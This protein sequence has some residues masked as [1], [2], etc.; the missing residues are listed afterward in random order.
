MFPS[1]LTNWLLVF[2]RV[3]A[4]LAL[5]PV[6][7]ARN[8]PVQ[9]RLAIGALVAF[10]VSS[11][12]PP[13]S[14]AHLSFSALLGMLVLELIIG[15][16]LGLITNL[17]FSSLEVAGTVIASEMGLN[18]AATL[19]P[20]SGKQV[21]TPGVLLYYL[22]TILFLSLDLHHWLLIAFQR[23]YALLPVGGAHL[24]TLLLDDMV[25]FTSRLFVLAIQMA[26][27]VI[28][29][30]FLVTLVFAVLSRAIPQMNVF[31]ESF[32]FRTLVALGVLG[33]TLDLV[34]EHIINYLRHLPEDFLH[35]AQVLGAA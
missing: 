23:T 7:S 29:V 19:N 34:A 5:F 1:D 11:S 17:L 21:D 31:S 27:P 8:I 12:L 25:G 30:S 35:V 33:L 2:I 28:A 4:M 14:L 3:S 13:L 32:A 15:L 6:F 22:A 26:A 18:M 24:R 9:V 16:L 20:L 10:L